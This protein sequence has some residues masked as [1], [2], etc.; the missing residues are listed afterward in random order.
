MKKVTISQNQGG[1]DKCTSGDHQSTLDAWDKTLLIISD[2]AKVQHT[3]YSY[4]VYASNELRVKQ[5]IL[6]AC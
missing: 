6:W 5:Y 1:K 3:K 2:V 4:C